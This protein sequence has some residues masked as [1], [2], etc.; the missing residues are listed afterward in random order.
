MTPNEKE[1]TPQEELKETTEQCET[2][3]NVEETA[4]NEEVQQEQDPMAELQAKYDALHND[5]LRL[6][7]DFDNYRKNVQKEKQSLLKYGSEG[8]LTKLL[9]VID[10]FDL[11]IKSLDAAQDIESVKEGVGLIYK[12]FM[13]FLEQQD[14]KPIPAAQGDDFDDS[15]HDAMTTFP[16][17]TPELKGKIVDCV[18]Q[19][20]KMGDKVIRYSKVV[21]GQ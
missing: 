3:D 6:M 10:D 15:I 14:V 17:P 9:P 16:A 11:A 12:K 19:G 20:Y 21:V 2:T 1:M 8:V 13:T 4:A 18:T 7:A 5:Y